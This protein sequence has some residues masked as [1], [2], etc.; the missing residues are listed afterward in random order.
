MRYFGISA[1]IE[2]QIRL[3]SSFIYSPYKVLFM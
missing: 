2:S 1:E 3:F